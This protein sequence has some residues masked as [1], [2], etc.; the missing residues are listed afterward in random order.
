MAAVLAALSHQSA[1]AIWGFGQRDREVHV[2][3]QRGGRRSR[4][5]TRVHRTASLNAVVHND[6]PL[7]GPARTLRDLQ[8]TV[9]PD[10]LERAREQAAVMGLVRPDDTRFPEFTRSEGERRL[11]ALCKAAGLPTPQ[12]NGRV[13]R[14]P[15]W[16]WRATGW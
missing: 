1:A 14:M 2:T 6:L 13:A 10:E 8:R 15:R 5:G 9:T 7:T 11:K 16:R 12:M 3:V 4:P